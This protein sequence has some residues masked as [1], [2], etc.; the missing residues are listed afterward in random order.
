[1]W[2]ETEFERHMFDRLV[3][4]LGRE[5]ATLMQSQFVV[6][7]NKVLHEIKNIAGVEPQ[8]SDHGPD[9]ISN[10]FENV[11]SPRALLPMLFEPQRKEECNDSS[12]SFRVRRCQ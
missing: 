9:H 1:M 7:R 12:Q 5:R 8:L 6:A 2:A 10:V 3:V 4:E 11:R